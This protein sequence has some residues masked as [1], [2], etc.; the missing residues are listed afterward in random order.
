MQLESFKLERYF[1]KYEFSAPYLLS[2]SDIEPLTLPELL[3]MASDERRTQW[4]NLWLGY[5]ESQGHPELLA[6]ISDLYENITPKQVIE[7]VPEEGIFISMN[8]LLNAGDHIIV[9]SP[10]YQSLYEIAKSRDVAVSYWQPSGKWSFD[11][12]DLHNLVQD[13]TRMIVINTPHNPT[14][15]HFSHD[16]FDD[17]INFARTNDLWLFSDEMY[18]FSE[19]GEKHR[20]ASASDVYEKAISLCGMSKSFALPGLRVGWLS[21]QSDV[22]MQ[23]FIRFKDYTTICSSAPSEILALI[24]LEARDEI[25]ERNMAII[26]SNLDCLDQFFSQYTGLFSWVRPIAGTITFAEYLGKEGVT[27]LAENLVTAKGVMIVPASVY[28][29]DGNFFRLGFGRKNMPEALHLVRDY[30][31]ETS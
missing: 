14:G 25:L 31:K 24:A 17:I 28:D 18:R 29:Y 15:V 8:T 10:G 22:A 21:T 27:E 13:N 23:E 26:Q 2:P 16:E 19:Y 4:D 30:I 11:I 3:A 6:A 5:T 7:V 12:S 1:A 9:M 20:L